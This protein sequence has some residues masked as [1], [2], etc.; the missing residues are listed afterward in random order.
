MSLFPGLTTGGN[1]ANHFVPM[2]GGYDSL[3]GFCAAAVARA[4]AGRVVVLVLPITYAED[5]EHVTTAERADYLRTAHA[6]ARQIEATCRLLAPDNLLCQALVLPV[7]TRRDAMNPAVAAFFKRPV[8][9]VFIPGGEQTVA[10]QVL[11]GTPLEQELAAAG[12][13]GVVIGGT[14]AGCGMLASS[15]LAGYAR[16]FDAE[17]SLSLGAVEVWQADGCCGP[18]FGLQ[19]AILDQHFFQRSRVGRLLNAVAL[20]GVPHVGVGVD[21]CTGLHVVGGARLERVFGRCGVAV[22]DAETY[23]GAASAE[24][25]GPEESLSLRNVLVHLLAPGDSTY[26]LTARRHSLGAPAPMLER[27]FEAL[28]LP[29]GAGPL[30]L[31]GDV[32]G[33]LAGSPVLS[34]F[35]ELSGG[36]R[37]RVAVVAAGFPSEQAGR[38]AAERYASVLG[39]AAWALVLSAAAFTPVNLPQEATG[40]LL[41]GADPSRLRPEL[42]EPVKAAWLS[43]KPVLADDAAAAIVGSFYA[44]QAVVPGDEEAAQDAFKRGGVTMAAGLSLLDVAVEP[45]LLNGGHWGRLFSLAHAHPGLLALGIGQ[46]TALEVT[47]GGASV[48][49]HGSVVVLDLRAAERSYG[50]N[51]ALELANGL[52]DVFAPG[53]V[54]EPRPAVAEGAV[55]PVEAPVEVLPPAVE[56][57]E[58]KR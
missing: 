40:I 17:N 50:H 47:D 22:L 16:G 4:H 20:P 7:L 25:L 43:G 21:N 10:M 6:R 58:G 29:A 18:S 24:F 23:G 53:E 54:V 14:S 28:A 49:G 11:S 39:A 30:L 26:D 27:A 45:R 34:R 8:S 32:G 2:G 19:D 12:Q 57:V 35:V 31:G 52:L 41:L 9:A 46:D 13:R 55:V 51:N 33:S 1:P 5:P 48:L 42:L 56:Q 37:A 38:A 44:T 3:S 15:M 36:E